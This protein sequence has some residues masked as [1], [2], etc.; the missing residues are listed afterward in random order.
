MFYKKSFLTALA[1]VMLV[2]GCASG[3][4]RDTG[5]SATVVSQKVVISPASQLTSVSLTTSDEVKEKRAELIERGFSIDA[6]M[7]RLKKQLNSKD[8]IATSSSK[9][10]LAL[11][12]NLDG[13]R[14]RTTA[15][16]IWAG[17]MAGADYIKA[18]VVV[19]DAKGTVVDKFQVE[20]TYA[21]G[22]LAGGPAGVRTDWLY[23]NFGNEVVKELTGS[24]SDASAK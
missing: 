15:G 16:A 21:F 14:F 17:F 2:A 10:N 7:E 6:L 12:V 18:S 8:L 24:G 9:Q 13:V 19:K 20:T 4:K 3:T 11:E 1:L 23:E 5:S 22:G